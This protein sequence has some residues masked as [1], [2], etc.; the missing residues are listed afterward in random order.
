M[1]RAENVSVADGCLRLALKKEEIESAAK[2]RIRALEE[3]GTYTRAVSD[4][5]TELERQKARNRPDQSDENRRVFL[6]RLTEG[7]RG[8]ERDFI[9]AT[10]RVLARGGNSLVTATVNGRADG[11]FVV[12]TGASL[13]T[14]SESFAARLNLEPGSTQTVV[15]VMAD[16]RKVEARPVTLDSLQVGPARVEGVRA[17]ILP[18]AERPGV[19]GL[20]GMSFLQHF[21]VRLDGA[22]GELILRRFEPH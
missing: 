14:L 7:T 18:G 20:L 2:A 11:S 4:F 22:S 9:T 12:D 10:V 13:V 8:L 17:A 15:C 3:M 21:Q 6:N 16:G 1:Q 19:D 5:E